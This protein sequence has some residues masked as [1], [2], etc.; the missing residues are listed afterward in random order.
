MKSIADNP[1]RRSP[2][3]DF[4]WPAR[5][6]PSLEMRRFERADDGW[7]QPFDRYPGETV[8][9]DLGPHVSDE[10]ALVIVARYAALRVAVLATQGEQ[11]GEVLN[12]ERVAALGYAAALPVRALELRV[13]GDLVREARSGTQTRARMLARRLAQAAAAAVARGHARGAFAL[14]HG[15]WNLAVASG[16]IAE[17]AKA[18]RSLAELAAA[19]GARHSA[20]L[21]SRR[22]RVL[23]RKAERNRIE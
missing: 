5:T 13:L 12:A 6:G 3:T 7:E 15:A 11:A 14:Y 2:S 16:A 17:G 10:D 20:K 4:V 21:W 9:E 23:E 1:F 19:E 22:A 18:A 8:L